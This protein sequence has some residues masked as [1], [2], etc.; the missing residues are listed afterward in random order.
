MA[1]G[2][3]DLHRAVLQVLLEKIENDPYPS[4]TMMNMAEQIL[5]AEDLAPY[6]EILMDKIR[7]D[8]FPSLD[9]LRRIT[10]LAG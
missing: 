2:E 3:N 7:A 9:L 1:N 8:R 10:S 5:E 4:V 6:T